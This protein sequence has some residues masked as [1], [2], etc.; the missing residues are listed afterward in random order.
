MIFVT[1]CVIIAN[2]KFKKKIKVQKSLQF[3]LVAQDLVSVGYD[4]LSI[5]DMIPYYRGSTIKVSRNQTPSMTTE[6]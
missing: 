3:A 6:L 1:F 4:T 2:A 5:G